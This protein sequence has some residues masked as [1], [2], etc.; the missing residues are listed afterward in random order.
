MTPSLLLIPS[1]LYGDLKA[2]GKLPSPKGVA[3]A[4][5]KLV[6]RDDYP[7]RDLVVLVQSDPAI[8]GRL[9][10][11]ANAAIFG[12]TRPIVSLQ[13][14]IVAL[15]AFRVR[16]LVLGFS[17]LHAHR[18][19]G[20]KSF[21]Y[22]VFW[23]RSLAMAIACQELSRFAQIP[24][25]EYFTVGLL[26]R[27]GELGLATVFPEVYGDLLTQTA[28]LPAQLMVLEKARF[29]F[30]HRQL[31][32]TMMAEWGMPRILVEATYH[33]EDPAA[34][35]F[36]AGTRLAKLAQSLYF[37]R[38][39]GEVCMADDEVRWSLL[40]ELLTRSAHLGIGADDLAP[41]VDGIVG[42]WREWGAMLEVRTRDVPPFV[43]LL[44]ASPPRA[45]GDEPFAASAAQTV[46]LA[47]A[48]DERDAL[49]ALLQEAGYRPELVASIL[50]NPASMLLQP[51]DL[52]LADI[53]AEA[54]AIT[55]LCRALRHSAHG[56]ETYVLL[57]ASA[58]REVAVLA[59]IEAGADDILIKPVTAQSLRLRLNMAGRLRQ[60]RR[61]IRR[62]RLGVLRS[63]EA[64]AGEHRELLAVA[65]TDALTG[66]PNR[67]HGLDYLAAEWGFAR[68][69]NFPLACLM[70]DIDHFKRI[71]DTQGHPAG[72]AVLR[73]L[74]TLLKGLS[75]VEDMLF[76]YGGEEF[77][78]ILPGT[79]LATGLRIAERMRAQVE[80]AIFRYDG[81]ELRISVS[82]GLATGERRES[83]E[84]L[85]KAADEALYEAKQGG[86]NRVVAAR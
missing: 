80:A 76:R 38:A 10:K 23:A 7:I 25:E 31:G 4:I 30:D 74:A 62:E 16:D 21:D 45:A 51:P 37:A 14:A 6:Q 39:L 70:L 18:R 34:A 68:A 64:F 67:R 79:D 43:Q 19:G 53:D 81:P 58:D 48:G 72:D 86:R 47:V 15:G 65:L 27:I 33:H 8:A 22:N 3:F 1:G 82:L 69:N 36:Q 52:L 17:V 42:R 5:I 78:L 29:G 11:F 57:V 12:R 59:A 26:A 66:L 60:L 44:A 75:R 85:L 40:P 55:A 2:T 77:A 54:E 9:L 84:A 50:D 24:S 41:L 28:G 56:E 61:E 13:K 83:A 71:N 49:V 20:C 46:L 73:Q 63:T 35:G 32:A